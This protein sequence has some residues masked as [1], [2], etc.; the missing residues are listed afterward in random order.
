MRKWS[1]LAGTV[2]GLYEFGSRKRDHLNG[3]EITALA[4]D[5]RR[6]W[7]LVDGKT[8][9]RAVDHDRWEKCAAL[10]G[11]AGTCLAVTPSGLWV[12]TAGA[13]LFRLEN[14]QLVQVE[15]FEQVEG[16][17]EWHTPWGDPPDTRSISAGSRGALYVNVHVGGVV[18][19][20]DGGRSW[21]PTLDI[22][23]DVHQVLAHPARP[24]VVL[25]AAAIG[26]GIS[27][28]SGDSW[29]FETEGFHARYSRAV[30]VA[31]DHLLVSTST[32]P[33]G[34]RAAIYRRR[35]GQNAKFEK[36]R[37]GL[38]D[39]F[40]SNID[41]F[42]LAASGRVVAFGTEEGRLFL[43]TDAGSSWELIA[44]RLP[45]VQCVSLA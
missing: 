26:L 28:D 16:R 33:G 43:S 36:C 2:N 5:G 40:H 29:R 21:Q 6:W 15:E 18:R 39:W 19:S 3:H 22:D 27:E 44:E 1:L 34:K 10:R 41:T 17:K 4:A 25:A 13:H 8:V 35:L 11:H 20:T 30:A 45:A 42:C 32:G 38:P 14:G 24:R 23:A 9:W 37:Q 7:A 12:G 31:A